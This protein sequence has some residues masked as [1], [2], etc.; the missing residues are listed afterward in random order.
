ML[1]VLQYDHLTSAP[2]YLSQ[3]FKYFLCF[4]NTDNLS[5]VGFSV[6]Y[7]L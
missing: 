4:A 3:L 1:S 6:L 5:D 2:E 7:I